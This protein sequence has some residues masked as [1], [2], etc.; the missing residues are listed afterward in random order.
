MKALGIAALALGVAAGLF[1]VATTNRSAMN[2]QV[3]PDGAVEGVADGSFYERE[4]AAYP[5]DVLRDLRPGD[6]GRWTHAW[7]PH[8]PLG[9]DV[10]RVERAGT[11]ITHSRGR[12]A[13]GAIVLGG[14][15]APA[16]LWLVVRLVSAPRSGRAGVAGS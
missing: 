16:F 15:L 10:Y 3:L 4:G 8:L 9:Y 11:T 5:T 7:H 2:F 6:R 14:G 13:Y 1:A 12:I